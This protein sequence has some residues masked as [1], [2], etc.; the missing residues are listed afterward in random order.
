[1]SEIMGAGLFPMQL[2]IILG[3]VVQNSYHGAL[4]VGS[5]QTQARD[6]M[7]ALYRNYKLFRDYPQQYHA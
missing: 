7:L 2:F 1:M 4:V 3:S 5:P 6:E